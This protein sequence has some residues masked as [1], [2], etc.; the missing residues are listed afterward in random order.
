MFKCQTSKSISHFF[1]LPSHLKSEGQKPH[2]N[3]TC[4]IELL[5]VVGINSDLSFLR[6]GSLII[7]IALG[8]KSSVIL[9]LQSRRKDFQVKAF[10]SSGRNDDDS[11]ALFSCL[12]GHLPAGFSSPRSLYL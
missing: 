4:F 9:T 2:Q 6:E 7:L 12:P 1:F 5:F 8:C 3:P 10:V 11:C